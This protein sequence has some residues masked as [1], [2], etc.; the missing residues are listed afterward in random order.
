MEQPK[1]YWKPSIAPCGMAV[2]TS[3]KYPEWK[4]SLLVGSL[5]FNYVQHV[6]VDG[7]KVLGRSTVL[8]KIGRVRDIRQAPDGYLYVVVESGKIIRLLPG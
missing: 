7:P 5:K 2:V 1:T 4:G 8:E 3:D 6:K